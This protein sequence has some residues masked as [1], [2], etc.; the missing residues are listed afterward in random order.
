MLS[1]RCDTGMFKLYEQSNVG[2]ISNLSVLVF[3]VCILAIFKR[4]MMKMKNS[5]L[6][7]IR[8]VKIT[9]KKTHM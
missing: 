4:E 3:G 9:I 7:Q 2:I 8:N 1:D 5:F 6:V